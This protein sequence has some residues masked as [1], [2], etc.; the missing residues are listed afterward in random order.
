MK[1]TLLLSLLL[2]ACGSS[3]DPA[4]TKVVGCVSSVVSV[5]A[6]MTGPQFEG[7]GT[8]DS[9]TT[10]P[11][12]NGEHLIQYVFTSQHTKLTFRW[13]PAGSCLETIET[14]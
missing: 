13:N 9:I 4:N 10:Y 3:T 12:I 14:F 8:P 1:Y 2:A 5:M 11:I 7:Y 6:A